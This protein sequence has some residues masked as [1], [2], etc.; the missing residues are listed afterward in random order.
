MDR[1]FAAVVTAGVCIGL[2]GQALAGSA[3]YGK[4]LAKL[5]AEVDELESR[6]D[7]IRSAA[8]AERLSLETQ[9][10]D[11]EVL[12]RKEQVRAETLRRMRAKQLAERRKAESWSAR[13]VEP[14]RESAGRLRELVLRSLPF[15]RQERLDAVDEILAGLE[16]PRADPALALSRLW[17]LLEDELK[18][19][20]E[21]GLHRQVIQL[22][23]ERS[24]VE[25]ARLGMGVLYFRTEDDRLGWAVPGSGGRYAFE[26][27]RDEKRRE[28]LEALFE[29][30]RKQI[31]SG[32]F[33]LPLP[34]LRVEV[35][36]DAS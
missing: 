24:L 31:R 33:E 30:L 18:L 12:L 10:G 1:L 15:K 22:E 17:Q 20:A 26:V 32:Y 4:K 9:K 14:A 2:C 21:S 13:L 5:R 11:L 6:L 29:A 23:G 28:A 8:R 16:G 27:L 3:D 7:R 19:T 35:S 34:E 25:V 36:A